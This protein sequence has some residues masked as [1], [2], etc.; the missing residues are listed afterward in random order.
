MPKWR[1]SLR[2]AAA[3]V[4]RHL[5]PEVK[6]AV[7]AALLQLL[8]NPASGE[9]LHGEL[10][11]LWKYR[12]R[13]YRVVYKVDRTSKTVDIVAVGARRSIYEDVAELVRRDK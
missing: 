10:A 7:K 13:R 3:G 1:L 11:G 5:P 9:P 12:V 4:I 8:A 2:T 6:R